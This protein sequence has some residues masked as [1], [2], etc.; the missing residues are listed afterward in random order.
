VDSRSRWDV[1]IAQQRDAGK[2]YGLE[3]F[4]H[5]VGHFFGA[6]L[7]HR[8]SKAV[9]MRIRQQRSKLRPHRI[10]VLRRGLGVAICFGPVVLLL[11][12]LVYSLAY[13][14]AAL[15][16]FGLAVAALVVGILNSYLSFVRPW[17]YRRR[18]NSMKGYRYIS[19]LPLLGTLSAVAAGV[20]GFGQLP[21]TV[22]GMAAV[23]LDTG[24]LPWFLIA[25]WR[26]E[27]FWD[28]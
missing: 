23:I 15:A 6:E 10:N 20:L 8:T 7:L 18:R 2:V 3:H 1:V 21:T 28:T 4:R 24:G 19:G 9:A 22:V 25:T 14:S 16:G 11:C 26:D 17:L 12:S 27:S 5:S 13:P